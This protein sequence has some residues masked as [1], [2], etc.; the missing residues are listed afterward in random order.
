[1]DHDRQLRGPSAPVVE[2][3]RCPA[4]S[5]RSGGITPRRAGRTGVPRGRS[6]DAAGRRARTLTDGV[7]AGR[8]GESFFGAAG[9]DDASHDT[10]ARP[11]RSCTGSSTTSWSFNREHHA[12]T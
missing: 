7:T 9:L 12:T 4:D 1:V 8:R 6:R 10:W 3:E 5:I 2:P 11:R